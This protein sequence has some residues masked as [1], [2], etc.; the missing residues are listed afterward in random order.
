MSFI[1]VNKT[2]SNLDLFRVPFSLHF[3]GQNKISSSIGISFSLCIIAIILYG[4]FQSDFLQ[5]SNPIIISQSKS[6]S[7][8]EEIR[9][10]KNH[11]ISINVGDANSNKVIDSTI[12]TIYFTIYHLKNDE[13]GQKYVVNETYIGVHPCTETDMPFNDS[14]VYKKQ[15]LMNSLC[16]DEKNVSIYGQFD[17]ED[18]TYFIIE[19]YICDNFTSNNTC[20]P[21]EVINEFLHIRF[22]AVI[23][24]DVF[25]DLNDFS[26]PIKIKTHFEYYVIDPKIIKRYNIFLK[27][28]RIETNVGTFYSNYRIDES[29]AFDNKEFDIATRMSQDEPVFQFLFYA[30]KNILEA[31]RRYQNLQEL[32]GSLSGTANFLIIFCS[33]IIYINNR[34]ELLNHVL[35]ALFMSEEKNEIGKL[36]KTKG[37]STKTMK[38]TESDSSI[39][40]LVKIPSKKISS[41][42]NF[43]N[44]I[45]D[46]K[47]FRLF[48]SKYK[49]KKR[50]S[51]SKEKILK[52]SFFEYL[53]F[54]V[55]DAIGYTNCQLYRKISHAVEIYGKEIDVI[56]ILKK[57]HEVDKL[58]KILLNDQ[59]LI[60][61]DSV[62]RLLLDFEEKK[63]TKR[64]MTLSQMCVGFE[65]KIKKNEE[66]G[67]VYK[68]MKEESKGGEING[69]LVRIVDQ[70]LS[71]IWNLEP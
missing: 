56:R 10:S 30:S 64:S 49:P 19:L 7:N 65:D 2:L 67:N 46:N 55:Y 39:Q 59:Q 27:K 43:I 70:N 51:I 42:G 71:K 29:F 36:K 8:A 68:R 62:S 18:L 3:N 35:N 37:F 58:K 33:I 4:F 45:M 21:I 17:E 22:F 34:K 48:K 12:F 9:F 32:L 52:I 28:V 61:F 50:K 54:L 16:L 40:N 23:F 6:L 69:R 63:S 57:I 66:F 31:Q 1:K 20:K 14:S 11:F 13:N 41:L 38:F 44:R 5:Q 53:K 15:N 25:L 60:L 47:I 26:N 24:H